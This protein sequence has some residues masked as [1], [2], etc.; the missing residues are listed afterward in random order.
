M[1]NR[2]ICVQG[3]SAA[4]QGR[5][6]ED[7]CQERCLFEKFAMPV[8]KEGSPHCLYI[9]CFRALKTD[10]KRICP[11]FALLLPADNPCSPVFQACL[12]SLPASNK[13]LYER[14]VKPM[15]VEK[16]CCLEEDI[17]PG[18]KSQLRVVIS[19]KIQ[20]V[21]GQFFFSSL[22]LQLACLR[23]LDYVKPQS[24][25]PLIAK[26]YFE[27]FSTPSAYTRSH[28]PGKNEDNLP[29]N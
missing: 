27:F 22:L 2:R 10:N 13:V 11:R 15:S 17:R 26:T 29:G 9:V 28:A 19:G 3:K 12:P 24:C 6:L 23:K 16:G 20:T 25:C 7:P 14:C 5:P 4:E 21:R 8:I 18:L 1:K